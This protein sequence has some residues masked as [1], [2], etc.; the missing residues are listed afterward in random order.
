MP[1][2]QKI[3][4]KPG[5]RQKQSPEKSIVERSEKTAFIPSD[6]ISACSTDHSLVLNPA[7]APWT[8]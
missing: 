2:N 5:D 3:K 1:H 8:Q 7:F 6:I 4:K